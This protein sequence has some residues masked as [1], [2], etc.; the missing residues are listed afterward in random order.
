[1]AKISQIK[2]VSVDK[3]IPYENNAKI[4]GD[5][6]VRMIADSINEFGFISPCIIDKDYNLI[7]GHG[8]VLA[9][10]LL[11][12]ETVPCLFVEGLTDAQ[13][14]A[15]I[16]ADNRLTEMGEWDLDKVKIELQGLEDMEF[17]FGSFEIGNLGFDM[18]LRMVS[19]D[20]D[21]DEPTSRNEE[22]YSIA[23][24]LVFNTEEEQDR[25][26]DF[27]IQLKRKH[28]ECETIAERV[29]LVV[30]EWMVANGQ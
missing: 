21:P 17:D 30:D 25:W 6:Q 5:D 3:L 26:Y 2:D 7:A 9:A 15:Y 23:Y 28:P 4:H 8:R 16:L 20:D 1:M 19:S 18:D 24:E 13:R 10:K 11:G 27:L 12:M 29:M 14:R 22:G